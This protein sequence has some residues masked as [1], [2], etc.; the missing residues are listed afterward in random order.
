MMNF[1]RRLSVVF[2]LIGSQ[3]NDSKALASITQNDGF[4]ANIVSTARCRPPQR[5]V[6]GPVRP[7]P[8]PIICRCQ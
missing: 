3:G 5:E 4:T 8:G 2:L 6:C 7:G 1:V